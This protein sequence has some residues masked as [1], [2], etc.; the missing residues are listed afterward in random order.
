MLFLLRPTSH[1]VATHPL[2]SQHC[3]L[4]W[5]LAKNSDRTEPTATGLVGFRALE[6]PPHG[7]RFGLSC[8]SSPR[9][10][11]RDVPTFFFASQRSG[12]RSTEQDVP[13]L[14]GQTKREKHPKLEQKGRPVKACLC[15]GQKDTRCPCSKG[16]RY[17][18]RVPQGLGDVQG[19]G[20]IRAS[21]LGDSAESCS[22]NIQHSCSQPHTARLHQAYAPEGEAGT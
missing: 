2:G 8:P 1:P 21:P 22:L 20:P 3:G 14:G 7:S 5:F 10:I 15:C 17:L 11:L 4:C 18:A 16:P 9:C 12:W 6:T 19:F 13:V